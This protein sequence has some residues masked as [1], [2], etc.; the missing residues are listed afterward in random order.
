MFA[1]STKRARDDDGEDVSV[2]HESKVGNIELDSAWNR[3]RADM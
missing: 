2:L 1:L 3:H